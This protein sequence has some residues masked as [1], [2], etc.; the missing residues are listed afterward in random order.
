M[1]LRGARGQPQAE[2]DKNERD[3]D[4]AQQ[5]APVALVDNQALARASRAGAGAARAANE[6]LNRLLLLLFSHRL[7]QVRIFQKII[8]QVGVFLRRVPDRIVQFILLN[9]VH[10]HRVL[11]CVEAFQVSEKIGGILL[12]DLEEDVLKVR[13]AHAV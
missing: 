8:G 9:L 1:E 11:A 13:H 10:A 6:V 12:V 2:E 3:H 5:S 7:P 4:L